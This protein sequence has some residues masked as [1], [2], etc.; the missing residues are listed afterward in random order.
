MSIRCLLLLLATGCSAV[1][2]NSVCESAD[3]ALVGGE[4]TN[5]GCERLTH[6]IALA[7][8]ILT[9]PQTWRLGDIPVTVQDW[10]REMAGVE[11]WVSKDAALESDD[12]GDTLGSYDHLL[13]E[14]RLARSE[15]SLLHELLH[16]RDCQH[17]N[18]TTSAHLGWETNGYDALAAIYRAH[19]R[20]R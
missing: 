2:Y 9:T 3:V 1:P 4:H 5:L 12:S 11:I 6:N 14:V 10:D 15:E 16:R 19:M 13:N 8:Q 17:L 20:T 18:L 7:R